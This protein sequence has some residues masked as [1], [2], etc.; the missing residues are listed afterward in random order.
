MRTTKSL[1]CT[2]RLTPAQNWD[3]AEIQFVNLQRRIPTGCM[4]LFGPDRAAIVLTHPGRAGM[5]YTR[6]LPSK[7]ALLV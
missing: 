2:S 5:G 3:S 4:R 7:L 1:S 6:L